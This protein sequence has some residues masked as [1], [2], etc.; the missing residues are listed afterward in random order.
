MDKLRFT[1]ISVP[2]HRFADWLF[3]YR[4]SATQDEDLS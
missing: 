2:E 4:I 1:K 3:D